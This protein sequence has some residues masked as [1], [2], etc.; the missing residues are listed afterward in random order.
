MTFTPPTPQTWT[1]RLKHGRTTVL[2]HTDPL[3]TFTTLKT[4]LHTALQQTALHDPDTGAEIALPADPADIQLGVP[5][6]PSEPGKGFQLGEWEYGVAVDDDDEGKGKGKAGVKGKGN[7]RKEAGV[8]GAVKD[9]PKGAGLRDGAV[10]AFRWRGDGSGWE[11]EEDVDME[12]R[13]KRGD[14]WGVRLP[15]F[16]DGYGVE[17]E[18]DL[19]SGREF[20]G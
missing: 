19:G 2:L 6:A 3:S 1:L 13:G 20:E 16:E 17:N 11:D 8:A 5:V 18:G 7:G 14:M 15:S 12:G 10:L 4:H 9:C